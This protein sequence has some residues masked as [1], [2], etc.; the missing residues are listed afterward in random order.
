MRP[1]TRLTN[2]FSKKLENLCR[3]ACTSLHYNFAKKHITLKETLT[4]RAGIGGPRLRGGIRS[5]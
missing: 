2:G 1:F 5:S 4:I 3:A